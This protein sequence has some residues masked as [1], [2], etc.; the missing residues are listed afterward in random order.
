MV[1]RLEFKKAKT[2]IALKL[3]HIQAILCHVGIH[4]WLR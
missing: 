3:R 2:S 1:L 4:Y